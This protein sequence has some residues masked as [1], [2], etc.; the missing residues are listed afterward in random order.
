MAGAPPIPEALRRF[1]LTSVPS[2][3]FVEALL[4]FREA[5]EDRPVT[6]DELAHRLYIGGRQAADTLEQLRKARI[7]E[8]VEGGHRYAPPAEL[9]PMLDMLAEHYRTH[10]VE[11]TSLIHAHTGRMAQHFADAFRLRKD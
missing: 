11:V 1:I 7:V 3:P 5:R 8:P 6:I 9:A 2:V 4:I 10:L